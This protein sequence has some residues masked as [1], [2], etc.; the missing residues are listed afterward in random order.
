MFRV[1]FSITIIVALIF[2]ANALYSQVDNHSATG[3]NQWTAT[4]DIPIEVTSTP[5]GGVPLGTIAPG[6]TRNFASPATNAIGFKVKGA[7]DAKYSLSG[8]AALTSGNVSIA[9]ITWE[10]NVG[11]WQPLGGIRGPSVGSD[12]MS[13]TD[14]TFKNN[15][16]RDYRVYPMS[17]SATSAAS[18]SEN[19]V[20]AVVLTATYTGY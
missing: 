19:P 3:Q 18:T 14:K 15:G 10:E 9:G 5:S 6:L 4:V 11:G 2:T 8:T 16:E 13:A 17:I 1:I 7:S 12:V 20:F